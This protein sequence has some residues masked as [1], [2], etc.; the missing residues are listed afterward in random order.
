MDRMIRLII[1]MYCCENKGRSF[2]GS[3]D[4]GFPA[5]SALEA[6]P[7]RALAGRALNRPFTL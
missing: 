4:R 1:T 6:W 5:N 7:D 3:G 2:L